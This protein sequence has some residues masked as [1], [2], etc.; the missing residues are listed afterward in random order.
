MAFL[1]YVY[2]QL[3]DPKMA[4]NPLTP[5]QIIEDVKASGS[6]KVK[7]A[8]ADIDGVLR[9]KY[10]HL[11]KFL[12]AVDGG[13]GFCD[14]V[15]GWDCN[16]E[17]YDNAQFTG[18]HSGY[19][20][21]PARIDLS[22]Y[23]RVPW[24]NQVPF[25]LCDFVHPDGQ[26]V[27]VCPRQLLQTIAAQVREAGFAPQTA[28]EFEWFNFKETP[29][30]LAEKKFQSMEP[31]T[32]GMFGYSLLRAGLNQPFF[33]ALMDDLTA[34]GVPIEGLHTETGPGVYEAAILY[35]D[36]LESG[37]RGVLFKTGVKEIAYR[38][39]IMPTFMAKW[40]S[41]LPGC[42]GHIHQSLWDPEITRNLF[43]D[44]KDEHRMSAVFKSYIAGQMHCI[45][46]ILPFFAPNVNS[47]KRLVEGHWAPTKVTWGRDNR[48]AAF[49]ALPG[50]AK[51]TRLETRVTGSDINPYLGLAAALASGLYGVKNKMEL[52]DEAVTGNAYQATGAVSLPGSLPEA[53]DR[54]EKS[55]LAKELFGEA[56][57]DHFVRSRRWEQRKFQESVT[58]WELRRYLEII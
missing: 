51:S 45:P 58:D 22:T 48:T 13:L 46:E 50:S 37:D 54:L 29:Q 56:F 14:V 9:G 26:P 40:N 35:G 42:S 18:W 30:T 12:S 41:K 47:Y 38:F 28:L 5:D 55:A 15:F 27:A 11:D 17:C 23:R 7:L 49:R 53:T 32:P 33:N 24:D 20:D 25:F 34:F 6:Q 57:V 8:I 44:E 43:F 21:A 10:I 39:G 36:P 31:L 3:E 16:D 1:I 52:K 19:P 2:V 4:A